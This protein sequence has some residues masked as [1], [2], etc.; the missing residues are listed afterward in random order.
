MG[1][2]GGIFGIGIVL[3]IALALG[4]FS[5]Y[6][7]C[8]PNEVLVKSGAVGGYD[9]ITPGHGV[10]NVPL[11]HRLD[12]LDVRN[13]TIEIIVENA[14]SKGG[15]PLRVDAVAQ[16]KIATSSNEFL[17]R[18]IE[19]F[20][21]QGRKQ[22]KKIAR[23]T[24]EGNLR[25]VLATMTP[26]DVNEDRETFKKRISKEADPDLELM[27][28][29]LNSLQIQ[30]VTDDQGYLDS[31]G[32]KQSAE[33][34]KNSRIAEAENRA[35]AS[36]RDAENQLR[37]AK[38]KIE[39]KKEIARAEAERRIADAK[40]KAEAMIAEER[41]KIGAAVAK[42]EAN[43]DVQKARLEQVKRQLAADVIQPA[44]A[45][46]AEL[47]SEAKAKAAKVIEDGKADVEALRDLLE[48]WNEAGDAARPLFLIQKFDAVMDAMMSTIQEIEIDKITVIDSEMEEVDKN[49]SVPMKAASGSEQIKETLGLDLPKM[50]QG[51]SAMQESDTSF[52]K[53]DGAE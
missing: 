43:L 23:E 35:E 1:F 21:A 49:G 47:E 6:D 13:M 27:G 31:I 5:I 24:L 48:T 42:A 32:R 9:I 50:V 52:S 33:L 19:R 40:S 39:S 34:I 10:F 30:S 41:S 2:F 8:E 17:D 22:V 11:L 53:T 16:V 7:T 25:G 18:A 44:Q 28:L 38:A 51:L 12:R 3:V 29:S 20:L 46:K 4:L 15:I 45:E 36:V 26:E 14:Y 37:K